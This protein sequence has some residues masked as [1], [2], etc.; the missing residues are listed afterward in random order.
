VTASCALLVGGA[1]ASSLGLLG[2]A[3][4]LSLRRAPVAVA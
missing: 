1:L 2:L 4:T 3:A